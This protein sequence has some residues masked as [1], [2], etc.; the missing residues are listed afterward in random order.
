MSAV[1]LDDCLKF[2]AA[3]EK[4]GSMSAEDVGEYR[5]QV[6]A[7]KAFLQARSDAADRSCLPTSFLV[8]IG[9]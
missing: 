2:V 7:R 1:E 5:R 4:G 8:R 6:L 3:C 9:V